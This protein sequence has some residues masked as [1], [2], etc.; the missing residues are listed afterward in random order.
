[1][2][3]TQTSLRK[4]RLSLSNVV[5]SSMVDLL[6][7]VLSALLDLKSQVKQAHWMI[8]GPHFIALHELFDTL[9]SELDSELDEVAERMTALG[10]TPLGTLRLA[11]QASTLEDLPLSNQEGLTLVSL[12]ADRYATLGSLVR[13][14]IETSA[15]QGDAD[16]SDLL[17]GLSRLLDKRLWFLE[18]HLG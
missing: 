15:T 17:T 18:A 2:P 7:P 6:Q 4:S 10:G 13:N 14:G 8:S 16:T 11:S 9:A 1:M 12:L 5:R 3:T